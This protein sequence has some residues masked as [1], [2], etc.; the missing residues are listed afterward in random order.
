MQVEMFLNDKPLVMELDTGASVSLLSHNKCQELFPELVPRKTEVVLKTYTGESINL[1]GEV[2]VEVRY[3][4]Q[5]RQL[6]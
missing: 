2:D 3:G 5:Q 1:V 4:E 6:L